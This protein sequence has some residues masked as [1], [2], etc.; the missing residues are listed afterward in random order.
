MGAWNLDTLAR[1]SATGLV[2]SLAVGAVVAFLA[3]AFLRLSGKRDSNS[4]FAVWLSALFLMAA[5][6][7]VGTSAAR[8][9]GS[10]QG[11]GFGIAL[12]GSWA[13]G[14]FWVWVAGASLALL[15]VGI[16]FW[17][18]LRLR[19]RCEP[20][21]VEQL[22]A[23]VRNTGESLRY[24]RGTRI[25]VSDQVRVPAAIGFFKPLIV[26]PRW[27]LEQLSAEELN[28]V[29]MHELE[30]LR[31]RDDWTNLAQKLLSALLFFHPAVWWV[32]RQLALEREMACDDAVLAQ[33]RDR[34]AYA[35]CLVNVAEKSLVRRGVALVQAAVSRAQQTTLRVR[36]ILQGEH[37][38]GGWRPAGYV[39]GAIS[40]FG[41]LALS[42][43]PP[44]VEFQAQPSVAA[45]AM[46]SVSLAKTAGGKTLL[47]RVVLASAMRPM[48]N[49]RKA[50]APTNSNLV[51]E[52]HSGG[53]SP[54][55]VPVLAGR[56]VPV[57]ETTAPQAILVVFHGE[58]RSPFGTSYWTIC[59]WQVDAPG[60]AMIDH[61]KRIP[62]KSI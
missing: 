36:Q 34:H 31:R 13:A 26:I 49:Q 14:V 45:V 40:L 58:Q 25:C 23:S 7:W 35:A 48:S 28:A 18:L 27:A 17:Q 59:V 22:P 52:S 39:L 4:R 54:A 1:I 61:E 21:A 2:N 47:P 43:A 12:P 11:S 15:R 55:G 60:R 16:A 38:G 41:L 20:V 57:S 30:H 32:D 46:P 8:V 24:V 42:Q 29:L 53:T 6:P 44:L 10:V 62:A 3:W 50:V 19:W 33:T 37:E 51:A 5:L 56:T 9:S